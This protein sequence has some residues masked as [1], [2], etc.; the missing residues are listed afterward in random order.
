MQTVR[1]ENVGAL[2]GLA[3][4]CRLLKCKVFTPP[5]IIYPMLSIMILTMREISVNCRR[6]GDK[7]KCT[8]F[9]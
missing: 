7:R 2:G 5:R 6:A 8:S 3:L 1:V 9:P 4:L